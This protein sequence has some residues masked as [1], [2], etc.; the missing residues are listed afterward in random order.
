MKLDLVT[1]SP[2]ETQ[3][4]GRR[5]GEVSRPG[6]VVLLTGA[7]GSGKTCLTQGIAWGLGSSEHA[8]SPTFVIMRELHGRLTLYH[9]DLYRLDRI[10]ETLDLGLD[11]YFGS[12]GMCVVEWAEKAMPLMPPDHLL[13]EMEFVA[14]SERRLRLKPVG[15]RYEDMVTELLQ[16]RD[17]SLGLPGAAL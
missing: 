7:L 2:E 14:D 5:L 10:E 15:Q 11:D 12:D 3:N 1:N 17:P 9:V 16:P 4:I 13:I 8:L 6:D